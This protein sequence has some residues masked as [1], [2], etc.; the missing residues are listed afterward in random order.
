MRKQRKTLFL[1]ILERVERHQSMSDNNYNQ[2]SFTR[3]G[4]VYFT[5]CHTV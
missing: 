2:F 5:P 1:N 4:K 3:T